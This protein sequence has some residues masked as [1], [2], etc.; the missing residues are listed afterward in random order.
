M[1][2]VPDCLGVSRVVPDGLT[3]MELCLLYYYVYEKF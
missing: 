1:G 3:Y 2:D